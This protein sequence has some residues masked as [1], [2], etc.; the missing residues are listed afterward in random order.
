MSP[1]FL[2]S[3]FYTSKGNKIAKII[4]VGTMMN[5]IYAYVIYCYDVHFNFLFLVYCLILGLSIFSVLDFFINNINENF[6]A[7][8]SEKAPTKTIGIF[9]FI[10][11]LM[12]A[13][14]WLSDDTSCGFNEYSA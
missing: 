14:L 6:R 3:A 9:L 4:W 8:F 13:F 5:N 12:F 1:I 11:A 10:I 7:W 2:I